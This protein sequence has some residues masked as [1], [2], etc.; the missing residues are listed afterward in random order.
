MHAAARPHVQ[1]DM[2]TLH[3]VPGST[4]LQ[5]LTVC[6]LPKTWHSFTARHALLLVHGM[7]P[8]MLAEHPSVRPGTHIA[9]V[10]PC[11]RPTRRCPLS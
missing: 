11:R 3:L 9:C 7:Q 2:V 6:G 10:L 8:P 5:H 4:P 1:A